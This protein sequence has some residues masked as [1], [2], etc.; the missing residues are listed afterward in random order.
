MLTIKMVNREASL[1][2]E[3]MF[4]IV[5]DICARIVAGNR[6]IRCWKYIIRYHGKLEV[7]DPII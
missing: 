1:T 3:N 7:I 4:F 2:F 6:K 5:M